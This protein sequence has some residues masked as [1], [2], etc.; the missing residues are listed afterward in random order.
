MNGNL[1]G[2]IRDFKSY[3]SKLI[4]QSIYEEPESRREWLIDMFASYGKKAI[5]NDYFK[6]WTGENHSEEIFGKKFLRIK[7]DY[8]HENPVRAGLVMM[9]EHYL[10][11]SASNYGGMKGVIDVVVI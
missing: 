1:S 8:I 11:S 10:Y 6:L 5:A 3:T 4:I 7:L 9:P 2:M